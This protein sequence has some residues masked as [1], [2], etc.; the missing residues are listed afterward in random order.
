MQ[1]AAAK[2]ISNITTDP[3]S[4]L[5]ASLSEPGTIQLIFDAHLLSC[6]FTDAAGP[7]S[8]TPAAGD[9]TN[10]VLEASRAAQA[11]QKL[12]EQQLVSKL[13]PIDWATYEKYLKGNVRDCLARKSLL[14]GLLVAAAPVQDTVCC[15]CLPFLFRPL[16]PHMIFLLC[17]HCVTSVVSIFVC[18]LTG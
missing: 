10:P 11:S 9:T 3:S 1:A 7:N 17:S 18:L 4:P 14:V 8:I 12:L 13:D 6:A 5:G 2:S 16:W 15:C